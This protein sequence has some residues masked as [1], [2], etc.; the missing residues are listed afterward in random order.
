MAKVLII[1]DLPDYA[2]S[3]KY[4]LKD[5]F[6]VETA[7][8]L[9]EAKGKTKDDIDIFL[10]DIRLDEKNTAN[11]DGIVFLEWVKKIYPDKP[12][13]LMSGYT[14]YMTKKEE[15]INKGAACFMKKPIFV[16]D[17]KEKLKELTILP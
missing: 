14:E 8:N 15:I 6:K 9:E 11:Y 7:F 5:E 3:L 2:N 16:S 10:V 1:D 17:L 4:A 13:I 12:V